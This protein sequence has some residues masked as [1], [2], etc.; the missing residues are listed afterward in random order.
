MSVSGQDWTRHPSA[1]A[2][3]LTE[4]LAINLLLLF[5][6][7]GILSAADAEKIIFETA[8][9]L[10]SMSKGEGGAELAQGVAGRLE[11]IHPVRAALRRGVLRAENSAYEQSYAL[12][13]WAA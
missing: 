7:K 10:R 8:S 5:V 1:I 13:L 4:S 2:V 12:C 11:G 9:D 6:E 3:A